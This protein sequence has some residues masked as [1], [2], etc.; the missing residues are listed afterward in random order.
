MITIKMA[1]GIN[2]KKFLSLNLLFFLFIFCISTSS[3]ASEKSWLG[4]EFRPLTKEFI[5]L[6]NLNLNPNK[7]L[8][9]TNVVR[10]SPAH[11][12]GIM[13][14]DVILSLNNYE[15]K[16]AKNLSQFLSQNPK[17]TFVKVSLNRNGKEIIKEIILKEYPDKNF[18][19]EW[20]LIIPKYKDEESI[21]KVNYGLENTLFANKDSI[22]FPK[23]FSKEILKKYQHD[24]FTI[25]CVLRNMKNNLKLYDQIKFINGEDPVNFFPIQSNTEYTLTIERNG[26]QFKKNITS[27]ANDFVNSDL[28]CTPEYA[29]FDCVVHSIKAL[30][31]PSRDPD[32]NPNHYDKKIAFKK[33]LDCYEKKKVSVI[34]FH[35]IFAKS[36]NLVLDDLSSYLYHVTMEYPEGHQKE[37]ENLPE[38]KRILKIINLRLKEFEKFEKIYP[39]HNM[40]KSYDKLVKRVTYAETFAGSMY[41]EDF[42]SSKGT[43][44]EIDSNTPRRVKKQLETLIDE[45]GINNPETIKFLTGKQTFFKKVGEIDYLIKKYNQALEQINW[46]VDRLD[47]YFDDMYMDLS[48]FYII[49]SNYDLA[50]KISKQGLDVAKEN[51]QNLYFKAGYGEILMNYSLIQMLYK[52]EPLKGYQKLLKDHLKNL[53]ALSK[54]EINK[55][56]KIDKSYYLDILQQL[57]YNDIIT[58]EKNNNTFWALRAMDYIKNNK[59]YNYDITYPGVLYSLIQGAVVDDDEEIFNYAKN[60]LDILYSKSAGNKL[61]LRAIL[62]Y[63][64]SFLMT[65]DQ[66]SFY[67][68]SDEF[69]RFV[70][71]TFD[72]SS[73][74]SPGWENVYYLY[75]FY[76]GK[77][78]I[79]NGKNDEAKI[80]FEKTY[81]DSNVEYAISQ[82]Q[83]TLIQS[84]LIRKYAPIL[85]EFYFNEKD[86]DK[87][88]KL[89]NL[90]FLKGIDDLKKQDLK[91]LKTYLSLDQIKVLKLFL[92]YYHDNQNIKKFDMVKNHF[93]NSLNKTIFHIENN[94]REL[95]FQ[96]SNSKIEILNELVQVAQLF[97]EINLEKDGLDIL[98]KV[99]PLIM[100]DLNEKGSKELWKPNTDDSIV[101]NIYLDLAENYF[102]NN[103][104]FSDKAYTIAQAGKN[105][106]TSRDVSKAIA[107]K[108]FKDPNGLIE[109]YENIKRELSVNLRSKQFAPKEASSGTEISEKLNQRNRELQK[110]LVKLEKQIRTK[111][112]AYFKLKNIQTVKISEIQSLLQK[113]EILLDYYFFDKNVRVASITKDNF[114]IL[115]NK[116]SLQKLNN[117][118]KKIRNSLIP[119][120]GVVQPYE[121]NKSF[122]LNNATFT[123]L[124]KKT[125]KYN[126]I[127]I[128]PD[129]PLNSIPLHALA[130]TKGENC[131]DCR[132]VKFN[133]HEYQF[134]YFPSAETFKNLDIIAQNFKSI[135]S[136]V[137]KIK[138]PGEDKIK[139][140]TKKITNKILSNVKIDGKKL[141]E[142]N[143]NKKEQIIKKDKTNNN[144]YYLG[145]G[146]PD[147]YSKTQVEK[148]DKSKKVTMLRSLFE[149]GKIKSDSLRKIYGPVDGSADE[150]KQVADYLSPFKSKILLRNDAREKNLKELDLTPFKII[151]FATH[152]EISG[153]IQGINEPFLVLSPPSNSSSEDGLLTMSEIMSFDTNADLVVLSACNTAA[154]DEP[155]SE[156]F[157]GLS[158]SFFMSGAK[159][160]LV[161]NWYVETYSAKE[162]VISLFKNL[163]DNPNSSISE[164]L[165][166]TMLNMVNNEKERSHPM[167]WAPFVVVGKNQSLF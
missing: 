5:E 62:N 63:S 17:D 40:K 149:N 117:L 4:V 137:I 50:I 30:E 79:R 71:N 42:K 128:I 9:V 135:K 151:H 25:V 166:I 103:K 139:E 27:S 49:N 67:D 152:G 58:A 76:K 52:N 144:L 126:N 7:K 155:G 160:V 130:K 164:G 108:S 53:D 83:V 22:L 19:V 88:N 122:E 87:I 20:V 1:H 48:D 96:T 148:I 12:G 141:S 61:K 105:L 37:Q 69:I 167:F 100:Q 29:D 14:G 68:E 116:V 94:T 134:N 74:N 153:A 72:I 24:N 11:L 125:N 159:S 45:K 101:S 2:I 104:A 162:I 145:I 41:T 136:D 154:G 23:Y 110:Q 84:F 51:Y 26:K 75:A 31:L 157:S 118:N 124:Q 64:G 90:L 78:L 161:S 65:Y 95:T 109:K 114:E 13:P 44:V 8:I 34:P 54:D 93:N 33:A 132:N 140:K 18:K 133:A 46:K 147:L 73:L 6:N 35:N 113:D 15:I 28:E 158:K 146:D 123:F 21:A 57:H 142:L 70:D 106:F 129:G 56:L 112:P 92:K 115:S 163:K 80:L 66:I 131:L 60:E 121:I 43:S 16:S 138:L 38:I 150:I 97:V 99:Y 127:I 3:Q 120:S 82:G 39:S 89:S 111:V 86:F 85:F 47:K 55:M 98:N 119:S 81:K 102:Q 32:G 156:G 77:S 91:D 10:K 36:G 143:K 59:D 165:N 107:K